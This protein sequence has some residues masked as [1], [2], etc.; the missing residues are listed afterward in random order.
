VSAR[1]TAT[2]ACPHAAGR[3]AL[4]RAP[5]HAPSAAEVQLALDVLVR[6]H[7]RR[8]RRQPC[9]SGDHLVDGARAVWAEFSCELFDL[10]LRLKELAVR[11]DSLDDAC[12][13]KARIE[14]RELHQEWA[15][16]K[17]QLAAACA[18]RSS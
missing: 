18:E 7:A 12:D 4:P 11:L 6:E 3:V 5:G 16:V 9:P 1:W 17:R 13:P 15:A 8:A 2:L 10:E 14:G